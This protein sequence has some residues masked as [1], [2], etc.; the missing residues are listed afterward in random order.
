[1]ARRSRWVPAPHPDW[2]VK[3]NE[4]GRHLDLPSVVPLNGPSLLEAATS[5]TGLSDFGS[6][7]W[8]EPFEV[9]AG[10]LDTESDLTLMG[11]VMTRA[12]L[13]MLL[14]ARLRI[15]DTYRRH[16][17]IEDEQVVAPLIIVGQGRTGTT[18]LQSL[19]AADPAND[20]TRS[21]EVLFPCPPPE[22]ETYTSDPRIARADGIM[23]QLHRCAPELGSMHEFTGWE[24]TECVHLHCMAFRSGPWFDTMFGQVPS[25]TGYMMSQD[26]ALAYRYEKRVLKLLQWRNPRRTWVT[27]SPI[28]LMH[29]PSVLEVHPDAGFVWPHRDPIKALASTVSLIGTLQWVRS[30]TPFVGDSLSQFTRSD[31]SAGMLAQPIGWLESGALP[32][33]RL[34]NVHYADFV[35]DPLEVVATIYRTFGL[36]LTEE[37][38]L[39]MEAYIRDNPRSG[40]PAHDYDIGSESEIRLEREAF[41][42]Y[43]EYF[44]VP[45]EA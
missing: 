39:A 6:D 31:L 7:P 8:R 3:V 24:P 37:A 28:T 9:P 15:E 4:E 22:A 17:E 20:T 5:N 33:E 13:V 1:M 40:R 35:R 30:D 21:W 43:Q 44:G 26:P 41:T 11:R 34:C 14:E 25:Y 16:P 2:L 32:R 23:R 12:H 36:E 18:V 45:N 10:A 29:L 27:K 19:L 38:R 42:A